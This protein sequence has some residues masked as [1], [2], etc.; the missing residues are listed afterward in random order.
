MITESVGKL[1]NGTTVYPMSCEKCDQIFG[2][3]TD[4]EAETYWLYCVEHAETS[5]KFNTEFIVDPLIGPVARPYPH[6][7]FQA[8]PGDGDAR[9]VRYGGR[10]VIDG[11][12][13]E[14]A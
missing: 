2:Y 5:V 4:P 11:R 8:D 12:L 6:W 14:S 13:W 7:P 10:T 9:A 1:S 3:T